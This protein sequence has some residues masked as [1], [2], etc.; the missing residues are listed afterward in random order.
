MAAR[1]RA[2]DQDTGQRNRVADDHQ[3]GDR[4][5][6]VEMGRKDLDNRRP[7]T[8]AAP[9]RRSFRHKGTLKLWTGGM[10]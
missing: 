8:S 6:E 5:P 7:N 4:R 1:C 9:D 2:D 3:H 10:S